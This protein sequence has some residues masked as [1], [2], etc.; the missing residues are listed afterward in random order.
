M[1]AK[2]ARDGF[3]RDL[4]EATAE[5][6]DGHCRA[7]EDVKMD[8]AAD[9]PATKRAVNGPWDDFCRLLREEPQQHSAP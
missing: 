5:S 6:Q 9:N 2:L 1:L 4:H 7:E 3:R 8:L